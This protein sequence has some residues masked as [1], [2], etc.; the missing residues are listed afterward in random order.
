MTYL[1]GG[2]LFII[3]DVI[4]VVVLAA[5]MLYGNA[6]ARRAPRDPA[7]RRAQ[8]EATRTRATGIRAGPGLERSG[9]LQPRILP[10]TR[11]WHAPPLPL[12]SPRHFGKSREEPQ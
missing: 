7:T 1:G 6:L 10:I 5:A 9:P 3:I 11:Y 12:N 2:W 8:E 4:A